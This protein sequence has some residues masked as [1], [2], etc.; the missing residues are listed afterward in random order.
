MTAMSEEIGFDFGGKRVSADKF[1][2]IYI[3]EFKRVLETYAAWDITNILEWGSGLTTQI[4]AAHAAR[5]PNVELFLTIDGKAAYQQA[6]FAERERPAFLKKLALDLTGPQS[7]APE[8]P[9]STY[10]LSLGGKFDLIFIDGRR[11]MEC[12]FAAAL[13]SHP[14]T[15]VVVHDYRRPRYQPILTLFDVIEDGKEFRVL[16]PRAGVLAALGDLP[17]LPGSPSPAS[18]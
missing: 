8:L 13:L 3:S 15:V 7:L 4:L 2:P 10:P 18:S 12:A 11:R 17:T 16:R 9:Y 6:I 1:R 5:L 14:K